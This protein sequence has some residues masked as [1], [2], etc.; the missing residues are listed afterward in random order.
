MNYT[1]PNQ[2]LSDAAFRFKSATQQISGD[3]WTVT[4]FTG[5][6]GI[7]L[8]IQLL[9][10]LGDSIFELLTKQ[11]K[12]IDDNELKAAFKP[13]FANLEKQNVSQLIKE[14]LSNTLKN[15]KP[16]NF[17]LDFSANYKTLMQVLTFVIKTNYA[18]F[19]G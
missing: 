8:G 7:D 16:I 12:T 5:T 4:A 15:S 10:L 1:Q 3:E 13:L 11:D 19:F 14:L 2:T 9:S 6:K 18:D 17:D